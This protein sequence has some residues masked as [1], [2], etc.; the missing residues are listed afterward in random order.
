MLRRSQ[1]GRLLP[2]SFQADSA[3]G[4]IIAI[5][6]L[7][8]RGFRQVVRGFV[9]KGE[10][11]HRPPRSLGPSADAVVGLHCSKCTFSRS[12]TPPAFLSYY[13]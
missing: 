5:R 2:A 1:V 10:L 6:S 4:H 11:S 3:R 12:P 9:A 13:T 8:R 7:A